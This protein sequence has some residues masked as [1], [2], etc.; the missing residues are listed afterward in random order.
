MRASATKRARSSA[1][2]A[3]EHHLHGHAA[4]RGR[5]ARVENRAHA[6]LGHDFA[7]VVFLVPQEFLR[8]EPLHGRGLRRERDI[9]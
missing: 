4:L 8:Q 3:V 7:D 6:A 2:G 5:V 1:T 9:R